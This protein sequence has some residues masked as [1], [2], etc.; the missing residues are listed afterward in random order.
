MKA[1][2]LVRQP[3]PAMSRKQFHTLLAAT[4]STIAIWA[5]GEFAG[6]KLPIEIAG[7]IITTAGTAAGYLTRERAAPELK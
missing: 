6:I 7:T 5:L 4:G 2:T 1:A 3:T